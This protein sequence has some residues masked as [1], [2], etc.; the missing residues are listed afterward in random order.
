MIMYGVMLWCYA[1]HECLPSPIERNNS[2]TICSETLVITI[3]PK[4]RGHF[5][6]QNPKAI[7][8]VGQIQILVALDDEDRES[9]NLTVCKSQT[10]HG[11]ETIKNNGEA[12]TI[13]EDLLIATDYVDLLWP[14][15]QWPEAACNHL[16]IVGNSFDQHHMVNS[17]AF[18]KIH[19]TRNSDN[20]NSGVLQHRRKRKKRKQHKRQHQVKIENLRSSSSQ[21]GKWC[22]IIFLIAD[23]EAA[24]AY[25]E[26]I[27]HPKA[28]RKG[29]IK[30]WSKLTELL[31]SNP[32]PN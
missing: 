5:D 19:T 24:D 14:D 21:A 31:A 27:E 26:Q 28:A 22:G 7:D 18:V 8:G 20:V 32:K 3:F 6:E 4:I 12:S 30:L 23:F 16:L 9:I 1:H 11:G 29:S 17:S 10:I 25:L 2:Y 15:A 13:Q